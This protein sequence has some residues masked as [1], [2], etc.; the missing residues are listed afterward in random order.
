MKRHALRLS[1]ACIACALPLT[2]TAAQEPAQQQAQATEALRVFLDCQTFHCDFDH[3]RREIPYVNWMRDRQDAQ[4]HILGTAQRT[5]GGGME[6]TLTFIGL[7]QFAGRVDTLVYVSS[8]TDTQTE[9]R[10]GLVRTVTLGLIPYLAGTPIAERL[11]IL[12]EAPAV[13][14]PAGP[15][16]D[17]WNLWVFTVRVGSNLNGES[18]WRYFSGNG[19]I[20]ANRTAEDLK[21]DFSI[22]GRY[23]RDAT[24]VPELD[25]TFVNEQQRYSFSGLAVWSI[26]DHWAAGIRAS[27]LKHTFVNQ[28]LAVRAGPALEYNLYPYA[29]STRRQLTFQYRVG[30]AAFNYTEVTVFDKTSEVRP[31]H[32]AQVSVGIQQ[33][34]GDINASLDASQFLHDLERHRIDLFGGFTI[35]LFRGL[36]FHMFGGASRI[37]DQLFLSGAGLTPEERLLRTRQF[38]T[39]FYYF[40]NISFS[41]RFG[42]KFANV[43]NPRMGGGGG[44][45]FFGF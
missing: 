16:E 29:E 10:A 15:V 19:S 30:V 5:G 18:E 28:D 23:S 40:A 12:Y 31:I 38:E 33:P 3:F 13:A 6:H 27:A 14:A 42:S 39:A 4:L 32:N 45:I 43:V 2:A 8:N 20:S 41:Y 21:L 22:S 37:K 36:N 7:E 35:R 25:T 24:D 9:V 26:G 34:W 11:R 1:A 44:M 17:P